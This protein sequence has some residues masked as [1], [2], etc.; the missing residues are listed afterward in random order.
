MTHESR[1]SRS[2]G[3]SNRISVS[4]VANEWQGSK[5]WENGR[6]KPLVDERCNSNDAK[7]LERFLRD[8]WIPMHCIEQCHIRKNT[9]IVYRRRSN[10]DISEQS[11]KPITDHLSRDKEQNS[12]SG[13]DLFIVVKFHC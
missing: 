9:R 5:H 6:G 11:S 3:V 7:E 4:H 8:C 12:P 2:Q 1:V 10:K 13:I